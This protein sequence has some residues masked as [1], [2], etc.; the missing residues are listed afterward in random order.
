VE[1]RLRTGDDFP[2]DDQAYAVFTPARSVRA[3]VVG[4]DTYFVQKALESLPGVTV[5]TADQAPS[6]DFTAE[7]KSKYDVVVYENAQPPALDPGN[8]I[9]FSALPPNLPIR[10]T[11]R[12]D[13]PQVTGWDRTDPLLEAV[14]LGGVTI[15]SALSLQ[16]GSG[17]T[18][19]A[20]SRGSPLV[21][22]WDQSGLKALIVAFDPQQTDLPLKPGFPVFLANALS[23][24]YPSWL[25]VQAEQV[26]AGAG[27]ALPTQGAAVLTVVKPDGSRVTLNA[28]GPSVEFYDTDE[29]GFYRVESGGSASEFAVSLVSESETDITPRFAAPGQAAATA[30]VASSA[31]R[32]PA[33]PAGVPT[34]IWG[35]L[36]AAA[37]AL[38]VAEWLA[39]LRPTQAQSA[40]PGGARQGAEAQSARPGGKP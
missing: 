29:A 22:T 9:L 4:P 19:L 17:F 16:P 1:A 37:L 15:G 39:W 25:A 2:V 34:P 20:S 30:T 7:E 14:P 40:R 10:A 28:A 23:W 36:A 12:L 11:G 38:I 33:Q 18:V 8:V 27:R 13:L 26:Q 31:G 21:L 6:G 3:L 5:S 35:A 24:F 32:A